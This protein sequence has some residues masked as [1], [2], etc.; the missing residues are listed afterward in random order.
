MSAY[1]FFDIREVIDP[2]KMEEYRKGVLE[3]VKQ[4]N[5]QYV[6][7]GGTCDSIEGQWKPKFPVIIRFPSLKRAHEWYHSEEY[8]YLKALRLAGSKG[9]AVFMESEPSDFITES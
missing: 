8:K 1:C 3:T 5:G 6:V 4:Y 2:E 9:D 7:L